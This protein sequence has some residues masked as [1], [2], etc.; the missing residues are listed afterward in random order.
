MIPIITSAL[1]I[2]RVLLTSNFARLL[3]LKPPSIPPAAVGHLPSKAFVLP[4]VIMVFKAILGAVVVSS[5]VVAAL[6]TATSAH[7]FSLQQ[8]GVPKTT[9]RAPAH[10]Y[11]KALAKYG[12]K[13]PDHVAAAAA[14]TGSTSTQ[15]VG[16][17]LEYITQ[18]NVG[19]TDRKSVV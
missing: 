4:L 11:A 3:I 5:A 15:S 9:Y 2:K 17:D 1:S 19:G 14:Q 18:V 12:V 13:V 6:P 10:A 16:G 7:E 8:I